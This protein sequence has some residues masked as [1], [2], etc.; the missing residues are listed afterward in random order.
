MASVQV[1]EWTR[2][3]PM[4]SSTLD[5]VCT[6]APD[7]WFWVDVCDPDAEVLD[8]LTCMD[9]VHPL[10]VED[11][12]HRQSRPKIDL[13][14]EGVFIIWLT[15]VVA[16][17][18][19]VESTEMDA[20]LTKRTLVTFREASDIVTARAIEGIR[21]S[22]A[23]DPAWLLHGILDRLVDHMIPIVEA[24]SDR[25]DDLEEAL[26]L[27]ASPAQ[28]IDL[29]SVRR[30]LVALRR[31]VTP[32]REV[33]R[34]LARESERT[35]HGSFWYFQDVLDHLSA[36]LDSIETDREVAAAVMDIYL[37]AQS[38][39]TND[40]MRQLTVVATIFMPLTLITGIYGMNVL[41][42]MWPPV[43]SSWSF[44]AIM[45]GMLALVAAMLIYFRRKNWW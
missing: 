37:S 35:E 2:S 38:N 16:P 28:L 14:G 42:G 17:D 31:L 40:I 3:T 44:P 41:K 26:L 43:S 10:T 4:H 22:V 30:D 25:L 7:S 5:R 1:W 24:R 36:V 8:G 39:R 20:H 29:Y 19:S 27:S 32:A 45:L 23:A 9:G 13:F 12:L 21:E 15:P 18:G 6:G 33:V 34:V 11:V